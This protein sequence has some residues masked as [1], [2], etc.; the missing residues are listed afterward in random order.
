MDNYGITFGPDSSHPGDC[1][2]DTDPSDGIGRFPELHYTEA[3]GGGRKSAFQTAMWNMYRSTVDI[4][5]PL[6]NQNGAM[7]KII[8]S[9]NPFSLGKDLLRI[10]YGLRRFQPGDLVICDINGKKIRKFIDQTGSALIWNGRTDNG[11]LVKSGIYC[12]KLNTGGREIVGKVMVI[13]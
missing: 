4:D 2:R 1:I 3:D 9:C 8:L 5:A 6:S 11:A 12:L 10:E 7:Q 13:R